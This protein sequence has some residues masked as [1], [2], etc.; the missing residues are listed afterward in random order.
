MA[1]FSK[2]S[3]KGIASQARSF[4]RSQTGIGQARHGDNSGRIH[5]IRTAQ[6]MARALTRAG[7]TIRERHGIS[8]L[9]E[10]TPEMAR[11]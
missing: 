7:N 2:G 1:R 6:E 4:V 8:S 11:E 5:S 10:I 3:G 9:R